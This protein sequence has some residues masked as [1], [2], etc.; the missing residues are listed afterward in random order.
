MFVVDVTENNKVLSKL[1]T[2]F[3]SDEFC[4]FTPAHYMTGGSCGNGA[5]PHTDL[6]SIQVLIDRR[7]PPFLN[8]GKGPPTR[9]PLNFVT[10]SDGWV[11]QD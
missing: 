6:K 9:P 3:F 5:L 2:F 8:I 11:S 1:D 4:V 7:E 10:I